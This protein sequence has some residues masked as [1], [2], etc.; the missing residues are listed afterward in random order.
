MSGVAILPD[1]SQAPAHSD[2]RTIVLMTLGF[3]LVGIDRFMITTL[4]PVIASDL[5]L[6][7]ADIGIITG[8]LAFAWGFAALVMGNRADRIG[9][10]K[11]LV[12]ALLVFSLLI[13]AS[14]LAH[15]LMALILVRV[16]MGFAD[17]AFTPASIA[18]TL[19]A[20]S[21]R[22][23]GLAI[24]VQQMAMPVFGLGIAPLIIAE[25]LQVVD[26]RWTFLLFTV[27][28]LILTFLV[29]RWLPDRHRRPVADHQSQR[30]AAQDWKAVLAYRNIRLAMGLM[31]CWLT[32]LITTSAFL[33][34]YL[35]DHLGLEF[36]SMGRVMSAIGIGSA[37]GTLILAWASDKIGRKA[38]MILSAAGA[39]V[40]TWLL[41]HTGPEPLLLFA[42]LFSIHFFN[43]AA[44]T[45]TVGPISSETVPASL[46]AT[47][48]GVVIAMGEIVGGGL[49]PILAGLF[50]ARFGIDHLLWL[51][52]G[53]LAL[54]LALSCFLHET[55]GA[56]CAPSILGVAA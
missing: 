34:S 14:G 11:V 53:A 13:G 9:R 17:G 26:W 55:R 10:R 31:L 44:I 51:P 40:S 50:A 5:G 4:Y 1:E 20:A 3:G 8:A 49:A 54:G 21:V 22:K 41:M 2:W 38:V 19:E 7:Y 23:R 24:G 47:A 16:V 39:L 15:G 6:D 27:P 42:T 18:T 32:C 48:S 45:L 36:G 30:P 37:L 12:G 56:S 28:G 35:M 52:V 29:W 25:L 46:I 43:N 33:P